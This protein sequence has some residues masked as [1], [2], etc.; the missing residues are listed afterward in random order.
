TRLPGG[1]DG[2]AVVNSLEQG[3]VLLIGGRT[4]NGPTHEVLRFSVRDER[5]DTMEARLPVKVH[6]AGAVLVDRSI[7]TFG[8]RTYQSKLVDAVC[9]ID[10]DTG[11]IKQ[12]P[13]GLPVARA[14]VAAAP[15]A[16]G[17]IWLIGGVDEHGPVDGIMAF[18]PGTGLTNHL[19][20]R[21]PQAVTGA[22][23]I[24]W[25]GDW[26]IAGG[27]TR[28]GPRDR[29]DILAP[30]GTATRSPH[31][32][33]W[34]VAHAASARMKD[35]VFIAGGVSDQRIEARVIRFPR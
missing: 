14:E 1:R 26:L 24:R 31:R 13:K 4:S 7:Y 9:R 15:A 19:T 27:R 35:R 25:K 29:V 17:R 23:V 10:L 2:V 21:L 34:P 8:G 5:L 3:Q 33:P 28:K 11:E 20:L 6:S 22:S 30:D 32:L 18:D 16:D 12:Q